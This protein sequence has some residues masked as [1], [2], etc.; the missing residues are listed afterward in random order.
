MRFQRRDAAGQ[1]TDAILDAADR[2]SLATLEAD[3]AAAQAAHN[4][5][6]DRTRVTTRA[7]DA[8]NSQLRETEQSN[9]LGAVTTRYAYDRHGNKI[10]DVSAAGLAGLENAVSMRYDA[11]NH[12]TEV[13][14][15]P[16][17]H[18]NAAGNEGTV[19]ATESFSYDARGKSPGSG[20]EFTQASQSF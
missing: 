19:S 18:R 17:K 8:A 4:A 16:F 10:L 20:L 6:A 5:G 2:P 12:V 14:S 7:F 13:S 15:G 9:T 1:F 3:Y 11:G